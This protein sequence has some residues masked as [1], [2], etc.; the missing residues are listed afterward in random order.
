[1]PR[2]GFEPATTALVLEK[3][4]LNEDLENF[5]LFAMAKL[6]LA[7]LTASQY[8]CKIRPFLEGK[9]VVTDKDAQAYIKMKKFGK[10]E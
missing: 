9:T 4:C 3:E 7:K 6:D 10:H 1:M 5:R 8:I 2:A